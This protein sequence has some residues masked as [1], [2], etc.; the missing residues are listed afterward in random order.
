MCNSLV[1]SCAITGRAGMTYQEAVDCEERAKRHLATFQ[2]NLQRPLLFLATLTHRSRLAD[3]ND[4]VFLFAKDHYFI[5]ETV[6]ISI[7]GER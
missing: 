7:G 4:D 5:G 1:W 2:E 3:L 6:D